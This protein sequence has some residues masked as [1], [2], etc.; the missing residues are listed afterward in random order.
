MTYGGAPRPR[1]RK[2]ADTVHGS[3]EHSDRPLLSFIVT[4]ATMATSYAR[5]LLAPAPPTRPTAGRA[6]PPERPPFPI[7][8]GVQ[9][10][11][12]AASCWD[13]D[14]KGLLRRFRVFFRCAANNSI[15]PTFGG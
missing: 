1:C 5:D 6:N 11:Y 15:L 3:L 2:G 10:P 7:F 13:I 4:D 12:A 9:K 8:L 14:L